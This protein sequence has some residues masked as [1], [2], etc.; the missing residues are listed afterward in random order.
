MRSN[1]RVPGV[2]QE[3]FA[4]RLERL[5]AAMAEEGFAALVVAGRGVVAQNGFLEWVAGYVPVVRHAYAVVTPGRRPALVVGT[6]A[7]AWHARRTTGLREIVVAGEGDVVARHDHLPAGVGRVLAQRRVRGRVGIVGL[8]HVVPAGEAP[9]LAEATGGPLVDATRLVAELKARKSEEDLLH[10]ERTAAIADAAAY[11]L[12]AHIRPGTTGWEASGLLER[13]VRSAGCREVLIFVSALPYFLQRPGPEALRRGDLVTVYVEITG[14][15]GYWVE[16]AFLV[17]LGE[18][19]G[20]RARLARDVLRAAAAAER[21]LVAGRTASSVAA[22]VE[23]VAR[24]GGYRSGIWH[25]HGVGV[26]HDLPVLTRADRTPL[27][28]SMTIAVH[29]NFATADERLGASVADTYVV[30]EGPARRLSR[31]PREVH[32]R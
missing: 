10:L 24:A 27:A 18:L 32:R 12:L 2:S 11:E 31:L 5:S 14:W 19:D 23:R 20:D 3:A 17:A 28:P 8:Q 13:A 7:D 1:P 29:P 21:R 26:D 4:E 16:L 22:A 15:S 6:A 9:L 30:G 25:G